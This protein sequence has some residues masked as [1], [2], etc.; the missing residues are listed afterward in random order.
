MI[1]FVRGRIAHWDTEYV[2]VDVR[3]IG[4]RLFTPNPYSFAKSD[5]AVTI[6]THHHVR[7][8]AVLLFGFATR[9]EQAMFRKL[10]EVSGIGPRVALG[11]LAGG[12]PETI[13]A[14]IQQENLVFLT[15]LP[16]IGKKTAQRMVLDLKDKLDAIPGGFSFAAAGLELE[17]AFGKDADVPGSEN[18]REAREALAAL[19]YTAAELDRAWQGLKETPVASETVDAL[20]KRALQ[21][22]FKG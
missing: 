22:L 20:M 9:E 8:D 14:A 17:G 16:G 5:D 4:Y 18:W 11:I 12:K 7:E 1:D 10:L 19:G 13:A 6:Y 21:Q 2:V 15:K 3:D